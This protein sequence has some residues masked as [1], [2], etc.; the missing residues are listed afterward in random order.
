[1]NRL[2]LVVFALMLALTGCKSAKKETAS[3]QKD[4]P[5]H[6]AKPAEVKPGGV[7]LPFYD[8]AKW[9]YMD[10]KARVAIPAQFD[11][12]RY[13]SEGHAAIRMGNYFGYIDTTGKVKIEPRYDRATDFK[14]GRARVR[15]VAGGPRGFLDYNGKM[16]LPL[17]STRTYKEFSDGLCPT[18]IDKKYGYVDT[19]GALVIPNKFTFAGKFSGGRAPVQVD[20]SYG[21]IDKKGEFVLPVKY[22]YIDNFAEGMA[23]GRF[24]DADGKGT[25]CFFDAKGELAFKADYD[26]VRNFAGGR[27]AFRQKDLWGFL[28]KTGKPVIPAQFQYVLDFSEGLAPVR[29]DR[30][31]GYINAEGSL[32]INPEFNQA[33]V[34]K[35]NLAY[36]SWP[37]GK[38]GYID[39]NGNVLWSIMGV[40][41]NNPVIDSDLQ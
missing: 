38:F 12:A 26:E 14:N 24:R 31:W 13:F 29:I 7:M 33:E 9:G 27:A 40:G 21:V 2:L 18:I 25:W 34:F 22:L 39:L 41:T 6:V 15:M 32:M 36:V 19:T 5:P 20:S 4:S 1:M 30:A 17:D 35:N 8:G 3:A 37:G 23:R 28:D 11:G 16:V 10:S